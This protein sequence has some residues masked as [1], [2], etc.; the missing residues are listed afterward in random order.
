MLYKVNQVKTRT[1]RSFGSERADQLSRRGRPLLALEPRSNSN[2]QAPRSVSLPIPAGN[3][4][5]KWLPPVIPLFLSTEAR[6]LSQAATTG[7]LQALHYCVG[8]PQS[9]SDS[10]NISGFE[11]LSILTNPVSAGG[12]QM[13]EQRLIRNPTC[14]NDPG[15]AETQRHRKQFIQEKRT[16]ES[17]ETLRIPARLPP[18]WGQEALGLDDEAGNDRNL[19]GP[20]VMRHQSL[21]FL[22]D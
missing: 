1:G 18:Q 17:R 9:S 16:R 6:T 4:R 21:L 5:A 3:R 8:T 22:L 10:G 11:S 14:R 19:F 15:S 12:I 7:C 2:D 13:D 20:L